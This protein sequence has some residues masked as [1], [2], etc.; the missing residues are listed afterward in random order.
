MD[1][2]L[3]EMAEEMHVDLEKIAE[4]AGIGSGRRSNYLEALEP[5]KFEVSEGVAA[6]VAYLAWESEGTVTPHDLK[7]KSQSEKYSG[8]TSLTTKTAREGLAAVARAGLIRRDLELD[9]KTI[10]YGEALD[11]TGHKYSEENLEIPPIEYDMGERHQFLRSGDPQGEISDPA[12]A[13]QA[14]ARMQEKYD[15]RKGVYDALD[16]L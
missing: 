3:Y 2:D 16:D 13:F 1:V 7:M 14:V 6:D 5:F 8:V 12:K 4:E 11:T 15:F 9:D 10:E